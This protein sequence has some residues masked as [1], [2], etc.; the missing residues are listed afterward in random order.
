MKGLVASIVSTAFAAALCALM[1]PMSA[2]AAEFA[3]ALGTA[4]PLVSITIPDA[5][6]PKIGAH[7]AEGTAPGG[8]I[9]VAAR[10][11][12]SDE[13]AAGDYDAE[14]PGYLEQQGVVFPPS[15]AGVDTKTTDIDMKINGLD[16]FI[17]RLDEPTT[18]KGGPTT[19]TYYAVPMS[20]TETLNI[21]TRG[22][23]D[24][25]ALAAVVAT[26]K[27]LS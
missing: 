9:F 1:P 21:V 11:I 26:I 25:A 8:Q 5:W 27:P 18:F 24:D 17:S 23:R 10:I 14:T 7:G 15:Q 4:K 22:P 2:V 16:A 6:H 19:L 3:L 20:E 12:K 13:K